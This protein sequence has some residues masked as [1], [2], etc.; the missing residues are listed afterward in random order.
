MNTTPSSPQLPLPEQWVGIDVSKAYLDVAIEPSA[1]QQR[2]SNTATGIAQLL[3]LLSALPV[4]LVVLEATGGQEHPAVEAIAQAGMAVVVVNPRRVREFAKAI[5]KLAKTDQIDA[6]VLARFGQA[7]RP[8]VRPLATE[9][10]REL[11]ELVSRRQQVME[12][13]SAERNRHSAARSVSARAQIERHIEWLQQEVKRLDEQ[14]DQQMQQSEQWQ[15]QQ[16]ILRS[17]PGVGVVT[18]STLIALLPELG[19]L[20]RQQ[21]AALVGVAPLNCDS[22]QMRGKRFTAGG[23]SSVRSAL[24][25]AAFVATRFNPTIAAFYQRLLQAGKPKKVALVACMRKLL[26]ILNALLKH[27]QRWQAPE[28][29]G[30]ITDWSAATT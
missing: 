14:I 7:V 19:A 21:I 20:S 8:E 12:M 3:Q 11:Q 17:L 29:T 23:R 18:A 4:A 13:M 5:G 16:A 6:Q 22:G 1:Q 10:L 2:Y 30:N 24:F 9:P 26:V 28:P 27:N 15:Q 25:M